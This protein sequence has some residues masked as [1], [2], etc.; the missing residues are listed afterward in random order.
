M[1]EYLHDFIPD[2][3]VVDYA[4]I[5]KPED[6]TGDG[7]EKEDRTWI[8]LSQMAM[9]RNAL[10]VAPTQVTKAGQEAK[11]QAIK[12]QARWVGKLGHV[13]VMLALNQ[14]EKEQRKGLMRVSILAHRH[15][16]FSPSHNCYVLQNLDLGQPH[17]D[18]EEELFEG[19]EETD[20][21]MD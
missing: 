2:I 6:R 10:V 11:Q 15:K 9:E 20:D 12:H 8:A 3:I 19:E 14:T 5:L 17:L 1:I 18:S 13:D 7:F 4:D 16:K 21:D